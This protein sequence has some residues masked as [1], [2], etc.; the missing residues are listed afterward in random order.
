V[1]R[2]LTPLHSINVQQR[3]KQGTQIGTR[4]DLTTGG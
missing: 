3:G 4:F 2:N 1:R